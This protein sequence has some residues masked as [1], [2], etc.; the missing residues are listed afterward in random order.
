MGIYLNTM[1]AVLGF[2]VGKEHFPDPW[3]SSSK[4][5]K[6]RTI[7]DDTIP[8]NM[9]GTVFGNGRVA[10]NVVRAV[11]TM[12]SGSCSLRRYKNYL[13]LEYHGRNGIRIY[14]MNLQTCEIWGECLQEDLTDGV[15]VSVPASGSGTPITILLLIAMLLN[16]HLD[17][18]NGSTDE[19][20]DFQYAFKKAISTPENEEC[21]DENMFPWVVLTSCLYSAVK[22]P[23]TVLEKA[24]Q[25]SFSNGTLSSLPSTDFKDLMM[26]SSPLSTLTEDTR[27]KQ[28]LSYI[29]SADSVFI[30][31]AG[32]EADEQTTVSGLDIEALKA[33]LALDIHPLSPTEEQMVPVIGKNY[34]VDSKLLSAARAIKADWKFPGLDLAPNF[35]LEGDAG[36]GKTAA[37]KFWASVF[38]I[39]RTKITMNPM[40][41]S[42]NLIGAFY[43]IFADP[44]D[45]GLDEADEKAILSIRETIENVKISDGTA[46]SDNDIVQMIRRAFTSDEVRDKI[47][48]AYNIPNEGEAY[49]DPQGCWEALGNTTEAPDAIEVAVE[50]NRAFE[51]RAFR[52]MN[53]LTEKASSGTV[54]YRFVLSELM[55]AF[56]NGWL[57]EI[58]EAASVLR[59][60]V[61]TELNSLLEPN[62]R[63]ELPNGSYIRRHPDTIV[64]IT[65]N[66][67]YGGNVDLN[68][69]LRD[70]CLF[71]LKM[72]LPPAEVMAERAMA[73]TGF[74]DA[75]IALAAAKTIIAVSDEAKSKN[76]RGSFGMRSLL[77]WM[78]DL[79]RGDYSEAAFMRRVVFKMT[80]RDDDVEL[81]RACYQSNSNFSSLV[82]M[83]KVRRV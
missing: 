38:G 24:M 56:Q 48:D 40:F 44:E 41:E 65:T 61:L 14:D 46:P 83:G 80:T 59:P 26:Q 1:A 78:L 27:Q 79:R 47:R 10:A 75:D 57:V 28:L 21:N 34:V 60:G 6:G 55:K 66:R 76:I 5:S 30:G 18:Y 51:R 20:G 32:V 63:I 43:P 4:F 16:P 82:K 12:R 31:S 22:A 8:R 35:I 62:G 52:L 11:H 3:N 77:A 42:A 23:G 69:S 19:D 36:S 54:S 73:Q 71:G 25:K 70:R 68:E 2:T 39:P 29:K 74:G 7:S 15:A 50:V 37:T 17:L 13:L 81:L 64:V 9:R 49:F 72:D 67:D 58:Q 53:I 33:E 45:W